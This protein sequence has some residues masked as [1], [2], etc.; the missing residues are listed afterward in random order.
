MGYFIFQSDDSGTLFANVMGANLPQFLISTAYVMYSGIITSM[1]ASREFGHFCRQGKGLR[2][3]NP[4]GAQRSTPWLSAPYRFALP[5]TISMGLLHWI[6]SQRIFLARVD[7][8]DGSF[9]H[10]P[11]SS[12][13]INTVGWSAAA[14]MS[15]LIV[16]GV[17]ILIL[18]VLGLRRFPNSVPVVSSS[19]IAIRAVCHKSARDEE[20]LDTQPIQFGKLPDK[21][22]DGRHTIGFSTQEVESLVPNNDRS[23]KYSQRRKNLVNR[24]TPQFLRKR[25]LVP[26][27]FGVLVGLGSTAAGG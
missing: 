12:A 2:V 21:N 5:L 9:E 10:D 6:V 26:I 23:N 1:L 22:A 15:S 7:A 20:D 4:R 8:Y 14:T 3:S 27:S 25:K 17:L 13:S 18:P 11:E 19:S 24:Y 16:S